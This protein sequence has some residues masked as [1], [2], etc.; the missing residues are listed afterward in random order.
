MEEIAYPALQE[1]SVDYEY[2]RNLPALIEELQLSILVSTYQA[3][4][5]VSIGSSGGELQVGFSHMPQGIGLTSTPTGLAVCSRVAAPG[6][7]S[8]PRANQSQDALTTQS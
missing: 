6:G 4:R 2:S 5:L 3:G 1:V 8:T 7:P